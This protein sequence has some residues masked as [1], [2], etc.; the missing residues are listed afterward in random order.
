MSFSLRALAKSN[1]LT[2]RREGSSSR[3][4]WDPPAPACA[5]RVGLDTGSMA[6]VPTFTSSSARFAPDV[7]DD[8]LAVHRAPR[9][10]NLETRQVDGLDWCSLGNASTLSTFCR[11]PAL[12]WLVTTTRRPSG[13]R[14]FMAARRPP[15]RAD[16]GHRLQIDN[17]AESD[18]SF[19]TT[20]VPVSED[21]G[22]SART[23]GGRARVA[24]VRSVMRR[25]R[26]LR[27]ARAGRKGRA[28]GRLPRLP[29]TAPMTTGRMRIRNGRA[30][31]ESAR[32]GSAYAD[33]RR[34][35]A[36][37]ELVGL[38]GFRSNDED[39]A[40]ITHGHPSGATRDGQRVALAG[41]LVSVAL[42]AMNIADRLM[43]ESTSV[44]ATGV[45]FRATSSASVVELFGLIATTRP[46]DD[47][48]PYAHRRIDS[49]R[50]SSW[51]SC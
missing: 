33:F 16:R 43:T 40:I 6:R 5:N 30:R 8:A 46:P 24:P 1:A 26:T 44:F 15:R 51:E 28:P 31:A 20:T 49:W 14:R 47:D 21:R 38:S 35:T 27:R 32:R 41:I 12:L 10:A 2:C 39:D 48:D 25:M 11:R 13:E 7:D 9:R 34:A 19:T 36:A 42:A 29:V 18:S 23:I 3:G 22:C 50:R 45:G 17:V 4:G 37:A